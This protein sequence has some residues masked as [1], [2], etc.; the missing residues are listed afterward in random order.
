MSPLRKRESSWC[1]SGD[2]ELGLEGREMKGFLMGVGSSVSRI[3]SL[4]TDIHE[5]RVQLIIP[6]QTVPRWIGTNVSWCQ[7]RCTRVEY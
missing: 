2:L 1:L 7:E 3:G 5:W 4:G 6:G